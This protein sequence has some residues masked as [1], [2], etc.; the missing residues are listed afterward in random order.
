MAH[1]LLLSLP[2]GAADTNH[3]PA[4]LNQ[5]CALSQSASHFTITSFIYYPASHPPASS[6]SRCRSVPPSSAVVLHA[7]IQQ[8]HTGAADR[9]GGVGARGGGGGVQWQVVAPQQSGHRL[10]RE[11]VP[12]LAMARSPRD[13]QALAAQHTGHGGHHGQPGA[14]S[15]GARRRRERPHAPRSRVSSHAL[16]RAHAQTRWAAALGGHHF[17]GAQHHLRTQSARVHRRLSQHKQ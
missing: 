14:A 17:E 1:R 2:K 13:P 10:A 3:L 5:K 15:V 8:C 9:R 4:N 12:A 11:P 7:A 6:I 16:P